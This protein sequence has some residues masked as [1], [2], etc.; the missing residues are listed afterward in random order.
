MS[1]PVI[2]AATARFACGMSSSPVRISRNAACSTWGVRRTPCARVLSRTRAPTGCPFG[3]VGVEQCPRHPACG[4]G[5]EF[6]AEV[7]RVL[8]AEVEPLTAGGRMDVRGVAGEECPPDPVLLRLARGVAEPRG[9]PDWPAVQERHLTLDRV[10][11]PHIG[12][13][14][15]EPSCG[16]HRKQ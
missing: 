3:V 12:I 4:D 15:D 10:I 13:S 8:H 6:P 16:R 9:V 7:E 2:I 1:I 14:F 5:R 11:G